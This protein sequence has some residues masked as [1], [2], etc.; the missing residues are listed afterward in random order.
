MK[1]IIL[2]FFGA[3]V[4]LAAMAQPTFVSTTPANKNVVLEEYTGINC[5]YCPDGHKRANEYSA[6]NPGRV[7]VINI[8]QGSYASG[9]PNYKTSFG[10]SLAGQTGLTG[11]PS[12]TVNRRVFAG[13]TTA[14]SRGDWAT[15]GNIVLAEPSFVN[16]DARATIDAA[17]RVLTVEVEAYYTDTAETAFNMLNVALLQNNVVGPQVGAASYNPTQMTPDG[18]YIHGHMLRHLLTGQWG[19]TITA[20]GTNNIPQGHFYTKTFTY[21]L[22]ADIN[23]VPLELG[24]LDVA[25][26]VT[27]DKQLIYTGTKVEPTY[28]NLAPI[29]A[30]INSSSASP[31]FGCNN[32]ATPKLI[33]KNMGQD[34]IKTMAIGYKSGTDAQQ[35]YNWTGSLPT[36][37][38]SSEIVLPQVPVTIGTAT[39]VDLEILSI[40][41][42]AQTGLTKTFNV[43]KPILPEA[44]G[45][46]RLELNIDRYGDE[47]TWNIKDINGTVITS[48]GPYTAAA[49]NGTRLI[50]KN[51]SL[52]AVG[53][54]IFEILDGYGD[55]INAGYG[56]GGYKIYDID[57][58]ILVSSNGK[59]GDGEKRDINL[60]TWSEVGLES[61]SGAISSANVYPNPAKDKATLSVSMQ[62]GT[63]A[64]ISVVD[65]MGRTVID[66]GTKSMGVGENTFEINTQDLSNGMYFV[67][68]ATDNG[69]TTKKF[70]VAK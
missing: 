25:V 36:F 65:V 31:E 70:N 27:K 51:L 2:S 9:T 7:V 63:N 33:V 69:I 68:V 15:K 34:T 21:T 46:A 35:T 57:S 3:F 39:N 48:G 8:H 30:A 10:D 26:F 5:T 6:A 61:V 58:N 16:V 52:P 53:C 1:K 56:A 23:S 60:V 20:D 62:E 38:N 67:K 59:F 44:K 22:P 11:Y 18:K 12:G 42:V 64:V 49:A 45:N 43:T 50:T 54:Y 19:D 40:N 55:G 14:L 32:L 41:G 4:A 24:D 29:G 37:A 66:L 13:T 28:T 17:T 47:T